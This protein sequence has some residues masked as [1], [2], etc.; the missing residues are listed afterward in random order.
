MRQG[1]LGKDEVSRDSLS[2]DSGDNQIVGTPVPP[3]QVREEE[4]H[5]LWKKTTELLK[6]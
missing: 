6:A 2:E 4:L 1:S 5:L 3:D